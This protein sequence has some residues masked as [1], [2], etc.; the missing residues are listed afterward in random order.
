[1]DSLLEIKENKFVEI[2]I[3]KSKF[4]A[5]SFSIHS[6]SEVEQTIKNLQ[7]KYSDATHVCYAYKIGGQEKASDDGEPQGTAGKPILDCIKKK[8]LSNCMVVVVRYFG[9]I[10]LGAGG[11]VR[12]YS[13][14]AKQVLDISEIAEKQA[15]NKIQFEVDF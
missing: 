4:L 8:N 12:A 14:S 2:E 13:N 10:K 5:F 11:L 1:M 7:Q 15:C 9:G 3:R 6:I